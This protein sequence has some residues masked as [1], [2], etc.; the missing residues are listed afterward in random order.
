MKA[1]INTITI[2]KGVMN[3]LWRKKGVLLPGGQQYP[4]L[5]F[6]FE[7]PALFREELYKLVDM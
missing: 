1:E 3:F 2:T 5:I 7:P 6:G 4:F